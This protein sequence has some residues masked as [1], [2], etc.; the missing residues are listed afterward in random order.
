MGQ[1]SLC[2]LI[3]INPDVVHNHF[4]GKLGI[5][6]VEAGP[7][8]AYGYVQNKE[9]VL[10]ERA[11]VAGGIFNTDFLILEVVHVHG[12]GFFVPHGFVDVEFGDVHG[13]GGSVVFPG[14][15]TIFGV[16][17]FVRPVVGAVHHTFVVDGF[18]DVHF[19]AEGPACVI[20]VGA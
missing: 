6:N 16:L 8:T 12:Y 3:L 7:L 15:I 18:D 11:H 5:V 2:V 9:E 14:A 4:V 17:P 20:D 10:V 19:A 13:V 1:G